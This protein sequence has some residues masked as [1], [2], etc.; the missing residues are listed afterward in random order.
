MVWVEPREAQLVWWEEE[1]GAKNSP[2]PSLILL[3]PESK[4]V[5]A[6]VSRE[7]MLCLPGISDIILGIASHVLQ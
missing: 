5:E 6:T 2:D 4:T 7:V 1:R 3:P